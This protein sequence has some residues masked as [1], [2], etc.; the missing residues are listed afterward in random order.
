M[1]SYIH[2]QAPL[3]TKKKQYSYKFITLERSIFILGVQEMCKNDQK[4]KIK[5]KVSS[6]YSRCSLLRQKSPHTMN[7]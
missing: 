3:E 2:S 1:T 6:P 4:S 7:V 5:K